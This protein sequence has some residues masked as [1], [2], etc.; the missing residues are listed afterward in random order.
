MRF[1]LTVPCNN[2]PFR[3]DVQPYLRPTRAREVA[4]YAV[5]DNKTFPCHKT[6]GAENG[7]RA[8]KAKHQQCAGALIL[9]RKTGAANAMFQIAERFGLFDPAALDLATPVYGSREAMVRAAEAAYG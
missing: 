5:H 9:A 4:N 2:C 8:R 7:Q 6:T 3:Y 1:D